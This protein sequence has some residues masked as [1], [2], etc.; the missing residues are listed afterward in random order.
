[1]NKA[2]PRAGVLTAVHLIP[3]V[4]TVDDAITHSTAGHGGTIITHHPACNHANI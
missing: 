3:E 1:M 4:V 2:E